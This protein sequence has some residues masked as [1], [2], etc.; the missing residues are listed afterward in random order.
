MLSSRLGSG[1]HRSHDGRISS[2]Q[3]V[4]PGPGSWIVPPDVWIIHIVAVGCGG[5]GING[6]LPSGGG[7][8]GLCYKNNIKVI[9]GQIIPYVI[10]GPEVSSLPAATTILTLIA[11]R[12]KKGSTLASATGGTS[13]GGDV[14]FSGGGSGIGLAGTGGGAGTYTTNGSNNGGIGIGLTGTGSS[15]NY[16]RGGNSALLSHTNGHAGAIRIIWGVGKSFPSN[17]A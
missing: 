9:P 3:L 17:A 7:G 15:G 2:I 1:I 11:N 6:L 8:G 4:T 10:S 13:S 12:G 14:N 16:G 5:D